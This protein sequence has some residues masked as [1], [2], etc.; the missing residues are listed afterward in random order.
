MASKEADPAGKGGTYTILPLHG[1]LDARSNA[2]FPSDSEH[3]EVPEDDEFI[4]LGEWI[5]SFVC[6]LQVGLDLIPQVPPPADV[7]LCIWL[8]PAGLHEVVHVIFFTF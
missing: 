5:M 8:T 4:D 7:F 1:N 3:G 2:P 6:C